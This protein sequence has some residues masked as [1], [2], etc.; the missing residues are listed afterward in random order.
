MNDIQ[1]TI[2]KI[3]SEIYNICKK[4]N[5]TF[6]AIGGTCIGAVR[7]KGFIP[8]DDD[9]DIAVPIEQYEK[10]LGCLRTELPKEYRVFTCNEFQHARYVFSKVE[11]VDTAFIEKI[12]FNYPDAY[13]G[14]FVDIMPISGVPV[15]GFK[16]KYF[17]WKKNFY[18]QLDFIRRFPLKEMPTKKTQIIWRVVNIFK[19]LIPFNRYSDKLYSLLQ[20]NPVLGSENV[21][22]VWSKKMERFNWIFD[23]EWFE[24]TTELPFENTVMS[25]PKEW[26]KY[27]SAQWGDYMKLPDE[28][29][30]VSDHEGIVDLKRSYK[31]YR[32][33]K[34]LVEE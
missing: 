13:K 24:G 17:M 30:R 4:N 8:W 23:T 18:L 7:H 29:K 20:K 14:V 28:S 25:C 32:N 5:I 19:P 31:T 3:Y 16:K 27:L 15:K 6:Y 12:D 21:G 26:D 22:Y 34:E 11:L 1:K 10:L 9:L 2:L 33:S